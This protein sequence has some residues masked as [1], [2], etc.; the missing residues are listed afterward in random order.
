[1]NNKILERKRWE[2]KIVCCNFIRAYSNLCVQH[3]P[4]FCRWFKKLHT[5]KIGMISIHS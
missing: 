1:M 4:P 2:K 5:K 3:K